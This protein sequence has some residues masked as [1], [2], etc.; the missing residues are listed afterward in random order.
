MGKNRSVKNIL[1]EMLVVLKSVA[2]VVVKTEEQRFVKLS[3]GWIKDKTTGLEWGPGSSNELKWEE[4]KK[5]CADK[6]GRLPT[7]RELEFLI[8]RTKHDPATTIPD[9]KS[10]WYWTSEELA[11]NSGG[12]RVVGLGYGSVYGYNKDNNNYVRPVRF[13]QRIRQFDSFELKGGNMI[14]YSETKEGDIL[15]VVGVGLPGFAELGELVRVTKVWAS[16]VRVENKNNERCDCVFN[17]GAARL[18]PTE[19]KEDYTQPGN[20]P[21]P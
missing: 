14:N 4:A 2:P 10:F 13:S 17:C 16:G 12:A 20:I 19:W 11:G 7:V 3:D 18:E 9:M 1:E 8:D 15:K 5:Y 21:T 6:G